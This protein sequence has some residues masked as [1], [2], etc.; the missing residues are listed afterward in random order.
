[1]V[2][3]GRIVFEISSAQNLWG[4]I[5]R[6]RNRTKTIRST[7]GNGRL[8]RKTFNMKIKAIIILL[9]NLQNYMHT[10]VHRAISLQKEKLKTSLPIFCIIFLG[11]NNL[12]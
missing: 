7:V 4:K 8:K 3:I 10:Q 12:F 9:R 1:M 6:R 11:V 5:R 2:E